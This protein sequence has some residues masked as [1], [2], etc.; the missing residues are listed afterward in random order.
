MQN[1]AEKCYSV[2]SNKVTN[3]DFN[4]IV[5]QT[6]EDKQLGQIL[7]QRMDKYMKIALQEQVANES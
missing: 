4:S 7:D 3:S 5:K 2:F 1:I 6:I